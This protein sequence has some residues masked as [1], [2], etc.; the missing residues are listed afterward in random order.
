MLLVVI[1]CS[2]KGWRW[3]G[4]VLDKW[5]ESLVQAEKDSSSGEGERID[6]EEKGVAAEVVGGEESV[7]L[8]TDEKKAIKIEA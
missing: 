2:W 6:N 5:I 1:I 7:L 8:L 4:G 3:D